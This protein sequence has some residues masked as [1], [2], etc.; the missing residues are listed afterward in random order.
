MNPALRRQILQEL[1][2]FHPTRAPA[3]LSVT[4]DTE[5]LTHPMAAA[6][7]AF[8]NQQPTTK[9][10]ILIIVPNANTI[11]PLNRRTGTF[12][13]EVTHPYAEFDEVG[14]QVDFASLT[15]DTT[16]LDVL[17]LAD[18]PDNLEF[19]TGNCSVGMQKAAKLAE[20]NVRAYDA[21]FIPGGLA[22]M[23]DIPQAP[24]IK[25]GIVETYERKAVVGAVCHGPVSLLNARLSDGSYLVKG[26]NIASFTTL[27][28]DNYA[29]PD[30]P[31]DVQPALMKQDG[32][33]AG[34]Y[35]AGIAPHR[36]SRST[37]SSL[38]AATISSRSRAGRRLP[39]TP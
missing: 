32:S 26:K 11:G 30:R 15:G 38:A 31:F 29:K 10:K 9:M 27:E 2:I 5:L 4:G 22:P 39:T 12:L 36:V 17:N 25:R 28:E 23:V 34:R 19:L 3:Y 20:V 16:Y 6:E 8:P 14:Y 13:S 1:K 33:G 24:L 35:S 18:D 37:R 7:Q 21:I